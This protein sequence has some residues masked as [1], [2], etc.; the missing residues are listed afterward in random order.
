MKLYHLNLLVL[1]FK[2]ILIMRLKFTLLFILFISFSILYAQDE[3]YAPVY[4][5]TADKLTHVP[6]LASKITYPNTC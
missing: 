3:N 4:V 2:F 5:G 1:F 6:S